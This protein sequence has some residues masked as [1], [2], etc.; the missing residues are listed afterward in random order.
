MAEILNLKRSFEVQT[1]ELEQG[2]II[3]VKRKGK[4][5]RR[6]RSGDP[7]IDGVMP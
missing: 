1:R 4:S 3:D 7:V 6:S 5:E 2:A